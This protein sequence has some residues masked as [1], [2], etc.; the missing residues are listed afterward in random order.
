MESEERR[1]KNK[2]RNEYTAMTQRQKTEEGTRE[3]V[4]HRAMLTTWI[5]L[6][7]SATGS[8]HVRSWRLTCLAWKSS[9]SWS[10]VA[11]DDVE[12][13]WI[14]SKYEPKQ[15]GNNWANYY[16]IDNVQSCIKWV[17]VRQSKYVFGKCGIMKTAVIRKIITLWHELCRQYF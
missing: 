8:L 2:A 12:N 11:L 1:R 17:L 7:N 15:R 4:A 16:D 5:I 13:R 10:K 9:D 6:V 3:E 14:E